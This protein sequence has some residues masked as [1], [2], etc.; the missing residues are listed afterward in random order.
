MRL[1]HARAIGILVG[2]LCSFTASAYIV[3][4]Y[5]VDANTLHLWHLN[6][7]DTPAID[8]VPAGTNLMAL[9][10][11]ARLGASAFAGYGTALNTRGTNATGG[12]VTA[13]LSLRPLA[14]GSLADDA[15]ITYANPAT[16]AFTVE[17]IV[18]TD[19]DPA[20]YTNSASMFIVTAENDYTTNRPWQ[21][22]LR[23]PGEPAGSTSFRLTFFESNP[24]TYLEGL[25]PTSGADALAQGSWYH[26]AATFTGASLGGQVKLYWTRMDPSRTAAN[27]ILSGTMPNLNPLAATTC[28]FAIGQVGRGASAQN[29]VGL[30]D[31]VRLS[32]VARSPAELMFN[33]SNVIVLSSPADEAIA[34]GQSAGLSVVASGTPPLFYQWRLNGLP[35]TG[36][37]QNGYNIASARLTDWGNYDVVVTNSTSAATSAVA[38]VTVAGSGPVLLRIARSGR[39]F[40]LSWPVSTLDWTVQAASNLGLAQSWQPVNNPVGASGN[41]QNTTVTNAGTQS[42]FR[43]QSL[44]PLPPTNAVVPITWSRFQAG[45]PI[46]TNAQSVI[47]QL[48]NACK[49]AMTVWW[50]N[51]YSAQDPTNYLDFGGTGES[52]IRSPAMQAYGLA[53]ALQTGIYDP[54]LTGVSLTDARNRTLKM[55]RSLGYRHLANQAGGWGND[56]QTALWA[57][58]AGTAGWMLWTNLPPT[59]QEYVRRMVE[60]E[61][62][63]FTNY[64]VPYYMNR[65]GTI[66]YPGDTKAEENAWNGSVV[67]LAVCMMPAHPNTSMWRSKA[68]ELSLS[69]YARPSDI[70]RTNLYH[71]RTL[72]AWL[73][74]SNVNEDGTLI[75]HNIVHPDY[76]ASGLSEY[77]PALVYLLAG[78]PVPLSSFFNLDQVYHAMV[79]LSFV[80]G[81]VPYANGK[82]N[83]PPGGYFYV[84]DSSNQP[85]GNMYFPQGNDWGTMHPMNVAT[86]D[87]T[88][89]AFGLDGL[90]SISGDRWEAQ[91]DQ[92]GLAMQARFTDGHTFLNTSEFSYGPSEEWVTHF[93]S[94]NFLTKWLVHQA[95]V[96]TTNY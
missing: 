75:N 9:D 39:N 23:P 21:F 28:D 32:K 83:L 11:S 93:T 77:Q 80:A 71:A 16:G 13:G 19:F 43:L 40:L 36:D 52:Q 12:G 72:A 76:M 47:A 35:I 91:H 7:S 45:L 66:V 55:I 14:A 57:G 61:A 24:D 86:L 90:V 10:G 29:F 8:S 37:T 82:T 64:A 96:Q 6:E 60:Y 31:E 95:P 48:R 87:A 44:L 84:R 62:N 56:W 74:G 49:Y 34:V 88:A 50:T 42:Y 53:V 54:A 65:A 70:N 5:S 68:Y 67:H 20:T 59:D 15:Y 4:P 25:V 27:E 89:R 3:G 85:T 73:N 22:R 92:V 33:S 26:V 63:R 1:L 94:K 69:T 38:V 2:F 81:A 51:K 46:D 17:A 41:E 58:L 78:R 79:D 30:I 18:R